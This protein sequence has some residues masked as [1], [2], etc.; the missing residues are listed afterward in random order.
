MLL[1]TVLITLAHAELPTGYVGAFGPCTTN[2][3]GDH[4][5]AESMTSLVKSTAK[6]AKPMVMIFKNCAILVNNNVD[7]GENYIQETMV[8]AK[9]SIEALVKSATAKGL[10]IKKFAED[11]NDAKKFECFVGCRRIINSRKGEL[12]G[13]Q[14]QQCSFAGVEKVHEY[15]EA[16]TGIKLGVSTPLP[17]E[18]GTSN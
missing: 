3:S 5:T 10:P 8:S 9:G 16:T 2:R 6:T 7:K 4:E 12:R 14:A 17:L 18:A 1:I 13:C 11:Y 15:F